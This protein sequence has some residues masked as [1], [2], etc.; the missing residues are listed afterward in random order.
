MKPKK[1]TKALVLSM[2]A[3]TTIGAQIF[4]TG[5]VAQATASRDMNIIPDLPAYS[6]PKARVAIGRFDWKVGSSGGG[7]QIDTP[8][9]TYTWSVSHQTDQMAGLRDMLT[10]ALINSGRFQVLEADL[11]PLKDEIALGESGYVKESSAVAK[12]D[13]EGSDLLV[14]GSVTAWE[15]DASGKGFGGAAIL[16]NLIGGGSVGQ[17]RSVAGLHIRIVDPRSRIAIASEGVEGEATSWSFKAGA[18]SYMA[19]VPLLGGLSQYEKTP[20]GEAIS[21]CIA[22]AVRLIAEKTPAD[23]MKY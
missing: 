16:S 9:G 4:N 8:Q 21:V 10:T 18:G 12:G 15:P 6:G 19:G 11:D 5:C 13:W 3:V 23:Y 1:A 2:L 22:E 7:V 17:K 14:L 20:M